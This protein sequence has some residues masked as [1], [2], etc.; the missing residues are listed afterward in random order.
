MTSKDARA[1]IPE[2]FKYI[3]LHDKR[4]FAVG[5]KIKNLELGKASWIIQVCPITRLL[6]SWEPTGSG[7]R[8]CSNDQRD[9]MFLA[10]KTERG[11]MSH[12]MQAT[13]RN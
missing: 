6:K 4:E 9:A 3:T 1:L 8:L 7:E 11:A 10:L 2:N 5:T 13:S 12:G